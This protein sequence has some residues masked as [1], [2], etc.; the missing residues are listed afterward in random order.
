M[1]NRFGK[2][3]QI[4]VGIILVLDIIMGHISMPESMH[5]HIVRQPDLLT[6]LSVALAGAATN[7]AAKG[8]V[9][10]TADVFVFPADRIIL[11]LDNTLGRF[12]L[13]ARKIQFRLP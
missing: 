9:G 5:G 3:G 12:L 11:F 10:R 13:G 7:T 4:E 1:S 2:G 6:N 8:E